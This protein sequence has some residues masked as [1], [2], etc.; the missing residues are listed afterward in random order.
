MLTWFRRL[1]GPCLHEATYIE[2]RDL[3]AAD[4]SV[5]VAGV[6]HFIC[7]RCGRHRPVMHRTAEEHA[8]AR[9][10]GA[11]IHPKARVAGNVR[12]MR[13]THG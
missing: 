7:R 12:P 6:A 5:L 10:A 11:V 8:S 13:R 9:Q 3:L 1:F 2:R 4:G